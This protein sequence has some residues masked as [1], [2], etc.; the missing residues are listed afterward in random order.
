M[1]KRTRLLASVAMPLISISLLAPSVH[2]AMRAFRC[3]HRASSPTSFTF[4][5]RRRDRK[6]QQARK[7]RRSVAR[8][9]RRRVEARVESPSSRAARR[10]APARSV[11]PLNRRPSR[12]VARVVNLNVLNRRASS[13]DP[14]EPSRQRKHLPVQRPNPRQNSPRQSSQEP[15]SPNRKPSQSPRESRSRRAIIRHVGSRK[16]QSR[17]LPNVPRRLPSQRSARHHRLNLRSAQVPSVQ[18]RASCGR[19]PGR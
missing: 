16:L 17:H 4:R 11:P 9:Q 10:V 7:S 6:V 14:S 5:L 2:A 19:A 15:N 8:R 1:P 18:V 13:R 3:L 12:R